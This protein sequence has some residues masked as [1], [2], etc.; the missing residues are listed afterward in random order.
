MEL[1]KKG[2]LLGFRAELEKQIRWLNETQIEDGMGAD[3]VVATE[4]R[5]KLIEANNII[6]SYRLRGL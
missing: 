3:V 2:E 4:V 1:T 6:N 5:D